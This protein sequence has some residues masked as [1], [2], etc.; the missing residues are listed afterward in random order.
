MA[1]PTVPDV[2]PGRIRHA[3]ERLSDFVGGGLHTASVPA[4]RGWAGFAKY[5]PADAAVLRSLYPDSPSNLVNLA[6]IFVPG[7]KGNPAASLR[8][9]AEGRATPAQASLLKAIYESSRGRKALYQEDPSTGALAGGVG[10][11][12]PQR[13]ALGS[14]D[15]TYFS[16]INPLLHIHRSGALG[17]YP[18]GK[19]APGGIPGDMGGTIPRAFE[20]GMD[21]PPRPGTIENYY[22]TAGTAQQ[23]AAAELLFRL[24][25]QG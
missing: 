22:P 17:P 15:L 23:K 16:A 5:D 8:F 25:T 12:A 20:G 2:I 4:E 11:P 3:A 10:L 19:I 9:A 14:P 1:F 7:A 6:T 18:G 13:S 24:L 21:V